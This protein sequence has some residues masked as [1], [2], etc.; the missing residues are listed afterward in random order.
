[1]ATSKGKKVRIKPLGDISDGRVEELRTAIRGA[2]EH[3]ARTV[4]LD[5]SKVK[6]IDSAG[7]GVLAAAHNSL[8]GI[9]GHVTVVHP[10]ADVTELLRTLRIHH[11][12]GLGGD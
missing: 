1:M 4:T 11:H 3:G 5:L 10:S 8:H 9:G 12:F 2:L 6:M 7:V